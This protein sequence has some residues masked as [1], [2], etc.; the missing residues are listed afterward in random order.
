MKVFTRN[1]FETL[2]LVARPQTNPKAVQFPPLPPRERSVAR[3]RPVESEG[4]RRP[5]LS[6]AEIGKRLSLL[7]VVD[8][9]RVN[10]ATIREG[11]SHCI[12]PP[13][14]LEKFRV[15]DVIT[16]KSAPHYVLR[17]ASINRI[18]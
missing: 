9:M 6:G 8:V 3:L 10:R 16:D 5:R 15:A 18:K 4:I 2:T 13:E 1:E 17:D 7:R 12:W 14:I 11:E